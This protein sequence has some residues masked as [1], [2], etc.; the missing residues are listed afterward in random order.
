MET[1]ESLRQ[2]ETKENVSPG[3]IFKSDSSF[4]IFFL[5]RHYII[6]PYR[7]CKGAP[8]PDGLQLLI[9]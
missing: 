9:Y 2:I 6:L 3:E 4:I 5:I 7:W 8:T 1:E